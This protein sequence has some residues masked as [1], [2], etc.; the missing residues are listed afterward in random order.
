MNSLP[1]SLKNIFG[2]NNRKK[3][4]D[5]IED[6]ILS[7]VNE[8]HEQGVIQQTEA[9]MI[10]NIFAFSDKEASRIMT[11][12]G[13]MIAI[14]SE[15]TVNDAVQYMLQQRNSRFPVYKDNIDNILGVV[16]LR[17]VVKYREDH[18]EEKTRQIGRCK[19]LI[20]KVLF[21]PETK[22]IDDLFR[23]MQ[24]EKLQMVIVVDEYGQTSGLVAM[25]DILEEIVGNIL[26]E[27]DVD[28]T[29]IIATSNKNEFVVEGRTPLEDLT[30]KFGIPFDMDRY[31]TV[32]G[33]I[34]S[35]MDRVPQ[36]NDHFTTE[37][38]GWRFRILSVEN[39]QVQRLLLT[40][41]A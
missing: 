5:V 2:K 29:H 4:D 13:D 8:G 1:D 19:E 10:S 14:D 15:M 6:E 33:F 26:D 3:Q 35:C 12:R 31:E 27:Y 32:N 28:E 11:H 16:H 38:E 36:P 7:I 25:E 9:E 18:P 34:M 30:R 24:K 23:Q 17:D 40:R 37:Y 41:L 22:N 39:R 20:R 21:V